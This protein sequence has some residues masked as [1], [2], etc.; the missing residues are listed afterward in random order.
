MGMGMGVD[1]GGIIAGALGGGGGAVKDLAGGQIEDQRKIGVAQ[2][3][4]DIQEAAARRADEF[5]AKLGLQSKIDE[6]TNDQLQ[7][8]N[9]KNLTN[10]QRILADSQVSVASRTAADAAD[11]RRKQLQ[12]STWV[13]GETGFAHKLA[14]AGDL[15]G[16]MRAEQTRGL[17]LTND[18]AAT[19]ATIRK[20]LLTEQGSENP[21]P[22]RVQRLY[23]QLS[24]AT[25]TGTTQ[26]DAV[27][28]YATLTQQVDSTRLKLATAEPKDRAAIEEDLN[29][30]KEMR[31]AAWS[32][33]HNGV[34]APPA[35]PTGAEID[36]FRKA[37]LDPKLPTAAKASI[38]AQT[39]AKFGQPGYEVMAQTLTPTDAT[40]TQTDTPRASNRGGSRP[41]PVD[42]PEAIN[43]D[44]AKQA[45]KQATS[46]MGS[47]G[48]NQR[49]ADPAGYEKA[50]QAQAEAQKAYDEA[51]SK[52]QESL[53]G[54]GGVGYA[55]P[56]LR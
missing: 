37:M 11:L 54:Y 1:W 7:G 24:A 23:Q 45:L 14:V 18:Q 13:Q 15:Q 36:K 6:A 19:V 9:V 31:D 52:Y 17:K 43:L 21:N 3:M 2:Q 39:Q 56:R 20:D 30:L 8:A 55:V 33:A 25:G 40:P 32:L 42:G 27:K 29:Q 28:S 5:R 34:K 49:G 4:S 44:S 41:F 22:E 48:V 12:D 47:Y 46:A 51:L 53:N 26:S 35:A 16:A 38:V 50:R 10:Q